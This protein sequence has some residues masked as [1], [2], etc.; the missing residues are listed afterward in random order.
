MNG[1]RNIRQLIRE[2][3]TWT[4]P[5]SIADQE[6]GF[7]GWYSRGYLPHFDAPG[8]RQ[9]I[10]YRLNDSMPANRRHEWEA[11]LAIEDEREKRIKVESYLDAGYGECYL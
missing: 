10:T 8:T 6:L 5:L 9:M 3:S 4:E 7:R 11:F 2:K 1:K